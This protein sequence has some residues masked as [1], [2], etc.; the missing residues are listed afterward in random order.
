M[1]FHQFSRLPRE[2]R[3]AIWQ[4]TIHHESEVCLCWPSNTVRGYPE[5]R[6]A[7]T[8]NHFPQLPLTVDTAYPVA[9]HVCRESRAVMQRPNSSIRF[10]ASQ[11]AGC[12]TPFREYLPELDVLYL[13]ADSAS[14][15]HIGKQHFHMPQTEEQQEQQTAWKA[16]L[17]KAKW[18]ALEGR[19]FTFHY[20]DFQAL[21]QTNDWWGTSSVYLRTEE[22]RKL[23]KK[24]SFVMA[25]STP[26][27]PSTGRWERFK[28]PGRRCK[29]INLTAEEIAKITV[30]IDS[31]DDNNGVGP[32][33]LSDAID[34][35]RNC[36]FYD[37][38]WM[39]GDPKWWCD[40]DLEIVPQTFIEYQTDGTWKEI[41]QQRMFLESYT[42]ASPPVLAEDRPD[43][44]VTR[45]MDSEISSEL[46][47]ERRWPYTDDG[48]H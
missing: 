29:L 2:I 25:G 22:S 23:Q 18:I 20:T 27:A 38:F 43:P 10:R 3:E 24:L 30:I 48:L 34:L 21:M 41:C 37:G 4:H 7:N 33:R 36:I 17:K 42:E 12:P 46:W 14:V 19:W 1:T 31:Y 16:L 35:S 26:M 45:V 13:S 6:E 5:F 28:A 9:M 39:E 44:R 47:K 15:L 40:D 8:L 32:Q 11:A